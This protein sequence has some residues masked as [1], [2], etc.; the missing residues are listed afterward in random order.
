[1]VHKKTSHRT[2]SLSTAE[3]LDYNVMTDQRNYFDQHVQNDTKTYENIRKISTAL[4][5]DYT[6]G[7]LLDFP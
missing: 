3:I 2:C 6:T 4:R 7:H 5:D 1:M